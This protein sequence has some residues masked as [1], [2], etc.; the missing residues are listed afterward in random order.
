MPANEYTVLLSAVGSKGA[1]T[2]SE[3]AA[4]SALPR[5]SVT[6]RVRELLGAG[7]L[8]EMGETEQTEHRSGIGH[9]ARVQARP[10]APG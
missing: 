10:L 6:L 8:V 1:A 9:R 2:R 3:L 4:R 7:L 5:S